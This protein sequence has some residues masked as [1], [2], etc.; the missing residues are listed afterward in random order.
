ME[1]QVRIL[2]VCTGNSARSQMAEGFAR[3]YGFEAY[4]AGTEPASEIHPTAVAVMSERSIDLS[5]Q[6]PK[7]LDI[8]KARKMEVVITVCGD[9]E[10]RCPLL[11]VAVQKFHWPLPDPD[12]VEGSSDQI[13]D[14]F[15]RVRDDIELRVQKLAEHLCS[16]EDILSEQKR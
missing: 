7:M 10:E 13:T 16:P 11:P 12:R 2:F 6:S 14:A 8:D 15:K 5:S 9:A 1:H 4:S 3:T